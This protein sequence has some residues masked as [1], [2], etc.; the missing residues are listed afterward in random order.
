MSANINDNLAD[1]IREALRMVIDPEIGFNIVDLGLVYRIT[2]EGGIAHITMTTTTR[3]CP[4]TSFLQQGARDSAGMV[5]GV[6][7]VDVTLTYDP[8][9]VPEMM[10][11][12]A[13]D[14]L[15]AGDGAGVR[16]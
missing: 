10:N 7:A 5:A 15:G 2:T 1:E 6:D 4:A 14:Y 8:P 3:G 12:E 11:A 9:W 16:W 13:K